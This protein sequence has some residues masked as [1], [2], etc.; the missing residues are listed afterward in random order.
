M[1]AIND[2]TT[3]V[4]QTCVATYGINSLLYYTKGF[5]WAKLAVCTTNLSPT[6]AVITFFFAAADI[7]TLF[8]ACKF[9]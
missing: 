4:V 9:G 3:Q 1:I 5:L 8:I 6:F 2:L 7:A